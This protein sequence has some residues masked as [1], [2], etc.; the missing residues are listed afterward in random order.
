M[1]K[2]EFKPGLS[3]AKATSEGVGQVRMKSGFLLQFLSILSMSLCDL[4]TEFFP[5]LA[6]PRQWSCSGLASIAH[7]QGQSPASN[8]TEQGLLKGVND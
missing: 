7:H 1:Q 4:S 2:L 3:D 8:H 6:C 5:K